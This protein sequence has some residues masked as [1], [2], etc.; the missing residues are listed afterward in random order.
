MGAKGILAG[1]RASDARVGSLMCAVGGHWLTEL[2][3][4]IKPPGG[5]KPEEWNAFHGAS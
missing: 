3:G 4:D 1:V 5:V 2:A